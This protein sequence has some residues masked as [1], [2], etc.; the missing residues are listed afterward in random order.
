[1]EVGELE[2]TSQSEDQG[3]VF[4]AEFGVDG[5]VCWAGMYVSWR[6]GGNAAGEWRVVVDVEF[7]EVEEGVGYEGYRAVEI[8]WP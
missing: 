2:C 3:D 8:C 6:S 5:R 1:M 7:E 4:L